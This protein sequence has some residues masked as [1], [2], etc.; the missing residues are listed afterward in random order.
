MDM[1]KLMR[2]KKFRKLKSAS[3]NLLYALPFALIV[4]ILADL[5]TVMLGLK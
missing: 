2:K 3:K 5:I 1:P 4:K